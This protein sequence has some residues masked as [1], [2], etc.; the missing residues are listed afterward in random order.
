MASSTASQAAF[1]ASLTSASGFNPQAYLAKFGYA[2]G[3]GLGK[4]EDGQ[5]THVAV[6][7]KDDTKG[8]SK[9]TQKMNTHRVWPG[10]GLQL[11]CLACAERERAA[12]FF[13]LALSCALRSE[14]GTTMRRVRMPDVTHAQVAWRV[15]ACDSWVAPCFTLLL[16]SIGCV[17]PRRFFAV[18]LSR[19]PVLASLYCVPSQVGSHEDYTKSFE[20]LFNQAASSTSAIAG[21]ITFFHTDDEEEEQKQK[22]PAVKKEEEAAAPAPADG[23][24][25]TPEQRRARRDAKKALKRKKKEQREAVAAAK[26]GSDSDD[27]DDDDDAAAGRRGKRS[28]HA[29]SPSA[30]PSPTAGSSTSAAASPLSSPSSAAAAA[31]SSSGAVRMLPPS[32]IHFVQFRMGSKLLA[33]SHA[34]VDLAGKQLR[35]AQMGDAAHMDDSKKKSKKEKKAKT[36]QEERDEADELE[37]GRGGLGM[38]GLGFGGAGLGAR[39][40]A[41]AGDSSSSDEDESGAAPAAAADSDSDAELRGE[42]KYISASKPRPAASH[43]PRA[44]GGE[45]M[46]LKMGSRVAEVN[47]AHLYHERSKGKHARLAEADRAY[48]ELM[49]KKKE[50]EA[51]AAAAAAA[52]RAAKAAAASS[53]SAGVAPVKIE[54]ASPAG[55]F[56]SPLFALPS[57]SPSPTAAAQDGSD[58]EETPEQRKERKEAKRAKKEAKRAKKESMRDD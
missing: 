30:S 4:N 37:G 18:L 32:S 28:K 19:S 43:I 5:T 58:G 42:M 9:Y 39:P 1:V 48:I 22:Q 35:K 3:K 47:G 44:K 54:P 34:E 49:R 46:T 31:S 15:W 55:A 20:K 21:G 12:S 50:D 16:V 2:A 33:G 17:F 45:N 52:G 57:P 27:A 11:L 14:P 10:C 36:K 38:G 7:K 41:A 25:E 56:T 29:H 26:K 6:N 53:S 40:S 13:P 24:E 8:V 51:A 23:E